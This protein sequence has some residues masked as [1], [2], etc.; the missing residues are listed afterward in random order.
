MNQIHIGGSMESAGQRMLLSAAEAA[1]ELGV[2]ES[3]LRRRTKEG[4]IQAIRIGRRVLYSRQA[5]VSWIQTGV[6]A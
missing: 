2:S 3:S 1:R 6:A 4:T 5:L